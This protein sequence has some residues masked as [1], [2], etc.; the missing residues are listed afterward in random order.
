V[1]THQRI[2]MERI[3]D[4]FTIRRLNDDMT[5]LRATLDEEKRRAHLVEEGLLKVKDTLTMCVA[6]PLIY[7]SVLTRYSIAK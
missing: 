2:R 7:D 1:D 3:N 5:S 4:L 6:L